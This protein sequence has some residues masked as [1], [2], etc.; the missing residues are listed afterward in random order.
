MWNNNK[1]HGAMTV[2]G[3]NAFPEDEDQ[4]EK[5]TVRATTDPVP[6]TVKYPPV[7]AL[8]PLKTN[9]K[10]ILKVK[11]KPAA[12]HSIQT[13][14]VRRTTPK[15][16]LKVVPRG[17]FSQMHEPRTIPGHQEL[18]TLADR[19]GFFRRVDCLLCYNQHVDGMQNLTVRNHHFHISLV[20]VEELIKA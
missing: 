10:G 20:E 14:M 19:L 1:N 16:V 11:P 9:G 8:A 3:P 7:M 15:G 6:K 17:P 2:V 13:G 4:S 12:L 18:P 5:S